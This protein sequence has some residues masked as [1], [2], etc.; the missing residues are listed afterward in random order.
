MQSKFYEIVSVVAGKD[1]NLFVL[2]CILGNLHEFYLD[3]PLLFTDFN[4]IDRTHLYEIFKESW[5]SRKL[6]NLIH[7]K[8]L[9]S[10]EK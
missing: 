7:T 2:K 4:S 8:L 10:N 1:D 6:V 3:F 9:D 5:I